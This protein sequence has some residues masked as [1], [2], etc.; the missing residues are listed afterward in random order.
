[1]PF[2]KGAKKS[3]SS[4]TLFSISVFRSLKFPISFRNISSYFFLTKSECFS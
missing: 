2:A 3:Y 4:Q 1:M